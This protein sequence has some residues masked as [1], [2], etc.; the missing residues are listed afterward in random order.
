MRPLAFFLAL[1][2]TLGTVAIA[3][4]DPPAGNAGRGAPLF[5]ACAMCHSLAPGG[6]MTG[7]SL[8][9]VWG[10]K[11]GS[12]AGFDR[13]SAALKASAVVW[14]GK[15][16]DQWLRAP[17]QFI[18]G[19][20]MNFA[21]ISDPGKRADLIAFLKE[22]SAGHV[23]AAMK[24]PPF[25]DLKTLG[26]DHQVAAIR[27][28][29]DTYRVTTG[30]GRTA[31]FWEANLRLKTDSSGTGPA[32]GKPIIMPAGMMGD[33]ASVFFAAP[34]EISTFIKEQCQ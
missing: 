6:N 1:G 8:A 17:A 5:R 24:A 21:G 9:G 32:S 29:H 10:R 26:P 19:N 31:A 34:A 4:A 30:D 23:P 12:L 15:T 3:R 20:Q 14:D 7:P 16:L 27:Y 2:L 13:Y 22:A 25:H 11:A 28:C 18:P 33:R